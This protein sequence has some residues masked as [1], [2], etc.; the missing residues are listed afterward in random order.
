MLSLNT[1]HTFLQIQQ[2][3]VQQMQMSCGGHLHDVPQLLT[4]VL[5][6]V[7]KLLT[8]YRLVVQE[9]MH[10]LEPPLQLV[11][12]LEYLLDSEQILKN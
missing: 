4:L 1:T 8:K 11:Q 6:I 3:H 10:G 9:Q 12:R 2:Q 7:E 5:Q